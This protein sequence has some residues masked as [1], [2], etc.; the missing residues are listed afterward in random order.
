[1]NAATFAAIDAGAAGKGYPAVTVSEG[2]VTGKFQSRVAAAVAQW[3]NEQG[4][5][6][7]AVDARC[8]WRMQGAL[9]RGAER[10]LAATRICGRRRPS[11]TRVRHPSRSLRSRPPQPSGPAIPTRD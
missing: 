1:M 2:S 3:C 11:G 7:V 6:V 10:E 9:A 4:A 8:R 5:E